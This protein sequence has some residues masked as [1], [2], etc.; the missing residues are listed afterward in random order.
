MAQPYLT[1]ALDAGDWSASRPS[2][3]TPGE[4]APGTHWLRGWVAPEPVWTLWSREKSVFPAE[5]R[6]LAIQPVARHY[7]D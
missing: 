5:N 6:T 3:F 4:I 7:T 1:S 2:R